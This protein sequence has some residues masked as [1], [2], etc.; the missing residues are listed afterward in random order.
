[1]F[2]ARGRCV[3]RVEVQVQHG[4]CRPNTYS[5]CTGYLERVGRRAGIDFKNDRSGFRIAGGA[6]V[7]KAQEAGAAAG[8]TVGTNLPVIG[9]KADSGAGVVKLDAVVIFL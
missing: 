1:M 2:E 7:H 5:T 6:L 3:T 9:W 8:G 4:R